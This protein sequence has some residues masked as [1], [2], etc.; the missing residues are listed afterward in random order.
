MSTRIGRSSK[1]KVPNQLKVKGL[2]FNSND[3]GLYTL[4]D[5]R[6]TGVQT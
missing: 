3:A 5:L 1:T 2:V 4:Y 6:N